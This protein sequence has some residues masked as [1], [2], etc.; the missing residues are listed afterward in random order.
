MLFI[1]QGG[2]WRADDRA[3]A[4]Q[5]SLCLSAAAAAGSGVSAGAWQRGGQQR[6]AGGWRWRGAAGDGD[7]QPHATHTGWFSQLHVCVVLGVLL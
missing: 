3:A 1:M 6:A 2:W 5:L 4:V 7:S